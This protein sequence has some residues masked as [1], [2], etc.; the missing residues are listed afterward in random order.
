MI[1]EM[2]QAPDLRHLSLHSSTAIGLS[3]FYLTHLEPLAA[4]LLDT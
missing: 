3:T 4:F 2:L 1:P